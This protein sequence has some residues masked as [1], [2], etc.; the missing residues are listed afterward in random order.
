MKDP[1]E[2][3]RSALQYAHLGF[4]FVAA[5]LL[6]Y[7]GGGRAGRAWGWEWGETAGLALGFV[8][9]LWMLVKASWDWEKRRKP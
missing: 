2:E 9:G 7:W 1:G 8:V 6:G 4:Q 3:W 5:V